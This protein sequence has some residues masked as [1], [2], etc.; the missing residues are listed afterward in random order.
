MKMM[1]AVILLLAGCGKDNCR[2]D[3]M[4]VSLPHLE[5]GQNVPVALTIGGTATQKYISATIV[6]CHDG[7]NASAVETVVWSATNL[8][9]NVTVNF[10]PMSE[11]TPYATNNLPPTTATFAAA[12]TA[13][14]GS[15]AIQ[16]VG[17]SSSFGLTD[18][19]PVL[20]TI[21]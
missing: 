2:A 8:P 18:A 15:Y 4:Q 1:S 14:A 12:S 3:S 5:G 9:A 20:L 21:Q 19:A 11:S 13:V 6:G 17:T 7:N 16:I 10:D